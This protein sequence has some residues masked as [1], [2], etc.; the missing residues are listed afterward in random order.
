MRAAAVSS[1]SSLAASRRWVSSSRRSRRRCALASASAPPSRATNTTAFPTR[2]GRHVD[3]PP[4]AAPGGVAESAERGEHQPGDREIPAQAQGR[5]REDQQQGEASRERRLDP[6]GP[7][8]AH[9]QS[10]RQQVLQQLRVDLAPRH[11]TE[12]RDLLVDQAE[13]RHP[14][15][16]QLLV[17][18]ARGRA[19]RQH[20]GR[21]DE[22]LRIVRRE[23]HPDG[24]VGLRRNRE[25]RR[26]RRPA[27][28]RA[29][30]C[31]STQGGLVGQA[32]HLE[33]QRRREPC[34]RRTPPAASA[35]SRRR[36]P[37]RTFIRPCPRALPVELPQ[38]AQH[39]AEARQ[40]RRE[41]A[42]RDRRRR[43]RT[44]ASG[45]G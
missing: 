39:R 9:G 19:T 12:R 40:Q 1:P 7:V 42:G 11:G 43:P 17:E 31:S 6:S 15:Q 35:G 13:P 2:R 41:V 45:P 3:Q 8:G 27:P 34:R 25:R 20:V 28:G 33:S 4:L 44:G 18:A 22:A 37:D 10:A 23:I 14:Q 16:H 38:A 24:A 32:Q 36:R 21:R 29:C 30:R 5:Q 26:P